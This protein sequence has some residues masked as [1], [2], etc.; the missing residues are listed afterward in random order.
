MDLNKRGVVV[1]ALSRVS[2]IL[3]SSMTSLGAPFAFQGLSGNACIEIIGTVALGGGCAVLIW[4]EY[5]L[6]CFLGFALSSI[7]DN[8]G[9]GR[10]AA[11][12]KEATDRE[13]KAS[14]CYS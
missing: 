5:V 10:A 12:W 6:A 14:C 8:A 9:A 7:V 1:Y 4:V 11:R 2:Q 13:R 3:V